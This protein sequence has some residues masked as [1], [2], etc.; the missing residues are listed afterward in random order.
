MQTLTIEQIKSA[1]PE[2]WVLIGDPEVRNPE[3]NGTLV[4]RLV[5]G[6]VL[7]A[8]KDKR[9]L[10]YQSQAVVGGYAETACIFTGEVPKHR[11]FLL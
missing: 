6:V 9:E 5:Q 10:A 11:I 2:Q 4:S 1:Y 3:T 8:N 7:L